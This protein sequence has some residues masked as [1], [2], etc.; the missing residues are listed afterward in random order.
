MH[1]FAGRSK[2]PP[3]PNKNM[4]CSRAGEDVSLS[5]I[6]CQPKYS[7]AGWT[8]T[9]PDRI[10]QLQVFIGG[11]GYGIRQYLHISPMFCPTSP[12]PVLNSPLA[13]L[14]QH[15]GYV[16]SGTLFSWHCA[17]IH[18]ASVSRTS[19]PPSPSMRQCAWRYAGTSQL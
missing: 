5:E 18:G 4:S 8:D 13:E 14:Q 1:L 19:A 12:P 2:L 11:L 17:S 9:G 15:L 3:S 6:H 10:K 16:G 7:M